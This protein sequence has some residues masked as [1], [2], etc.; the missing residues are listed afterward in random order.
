MFSFDLLR[1]I[2]GTIKKNKLRTALTG[3]SVAW[4]IFMLIVLVGAG[5]GLKNGMMYNFRNMATNRIMV[6]P[7]YSSMPYK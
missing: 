5:N 6:W 1:E 2:L 3:F 7:G 4:G